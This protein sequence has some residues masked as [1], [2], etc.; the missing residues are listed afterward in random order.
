MNVREL[1]RKA[2]GVE[3]LVATERTSRSSVTVPLRRRLWLWRHGFLTRSGVLYDLEKGTADQFVS[4]YRR[5]VRTK[6]INGTWSVA[7]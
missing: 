3:A 6:S 4:D 5:F 7:L 2:R 1:Y